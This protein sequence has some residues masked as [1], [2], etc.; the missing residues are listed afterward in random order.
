MPV[1]PARRPAARAAAVAAYFDQSY[2]PSLWA[3]V[4]ATGAVAGTPGTFTPQG[5]SLPAT[6]NPGML[7]LMADPVTA[8]PAGSY[9]VA[10]DGTE[11]Y[12]DGEAWAQGRAPVA[13]PA[14]T[15]VTAGTPGAFTP[16]GATVP[17]TIGDLRTLALLEAGTD[18]A[19]AEGT[20][21]VIGS[22]NVHWDGTD[23]AMGAAP[24]PEPEAAP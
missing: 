18:A 13:A 17:A 4:A 10:G 6:G 21:V 1:T 11:W 15:G 8:W 7:T 12:W 2:P 9:V 19:W 24:A 20:Y 22:G 3:G 16:S 23:W 14:P 5:A